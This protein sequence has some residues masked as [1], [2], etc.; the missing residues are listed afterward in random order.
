M[1]FSGIF[2]TSNLKI[3]ELVF[4]R[5]LFILEQICLVQMYPRQGIPLQQQGLRG[6]DLWHRHGLVPRT[7]N[8]HNLLAAKKAYQNGDSNLDMD[9]LPRC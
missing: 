5:N 1:Q 3:I 2:E 4:L 7:H 8:I 9:G 6:R